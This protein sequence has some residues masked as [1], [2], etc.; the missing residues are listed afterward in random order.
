MFN[1]KPKKVIEAPIKNWGKK[2]DGEKRELFMKKC[3]EVDAHNARIRHN[4]DLDR[5]HIVDCIT[6][7]AVKI[8]KRRR[9]FIVDFKPKF[10]QRV[11]T[12]VKIWNDKR[13]GIWR[14]RS[15]YANGR[16]EYVD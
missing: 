6:K 5:K 10:I 1:F 14:P 7:E 4:G 9:S 11:I 8:M 12:A 2:T 16:W 13:K 15:K 3:D